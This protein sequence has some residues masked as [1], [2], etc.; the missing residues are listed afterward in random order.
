MIDFRIIFWQPVKPH[1]LTLSFDGFITEINPPCAALFGAVQ[2]ELV[3]C[4]ILQLITLI[5][6][7]RWYLFCKSMLESLESEHNLNVS[8]L[9]TDNTVFH[10]KLNCLIVALADNSRVIRI[11]LTHIHSM[12]YAHK[13]QC[14]HLT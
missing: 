5:D 13:P 11:S 9:R 14:S 12:F 3:G 8:L 7:N 6:R 4:H 10:A 1:Y 2:H